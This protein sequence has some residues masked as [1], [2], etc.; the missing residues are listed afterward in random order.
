M[1][2][3]LSLNVSL[4]FR[5]TVL[6]VT[7]TGTSGI[8]TGI[9]RIC[10]SCDMS[11]TSLL[12]HTFKTNFQCYISKFSARGPAFCGTPDENTSTC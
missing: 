4:L 12:F 6:E 2:R 9:S 10:E 3:E 5:V 11:S 1:S 7:G 8:G